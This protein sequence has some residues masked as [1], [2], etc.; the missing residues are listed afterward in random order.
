MKNINIDKIIYSINIILR[1][2]GLYIEDDISYKR[3]ISKHYIQEKDK[4]NKS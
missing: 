4:A 2:T 3:L 1:T